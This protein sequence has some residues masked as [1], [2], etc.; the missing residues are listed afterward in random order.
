MFL[1]LN[2]PTE[3]VQKRL[4]ERGKT[5]GRSDDNSEAIKNRMDTYVNETLPVVDFYMRQNNPNYVQINAD[6][7][8][9][10]VWKEV[11]QQVDKLKYVSQ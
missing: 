4:I 1:F 2:V 9:E 3:I 11:K 6:Q 5:S 7:T 8:E 10:K